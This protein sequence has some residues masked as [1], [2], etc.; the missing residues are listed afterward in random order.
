[1]MLYIVWATT[2]ISDIRDQQRIREN[3]QQ[4]IATC[5][6]NLAGFVDRWNDATPYMKV[7]EFVRQKIMWDSGTFEANSSAAIPLE[8]AELHL[9]QLRKSYLHRAV[10]GMIEDMIYGRSIHQDILEEDD[11][12]MS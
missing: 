2:P 5:A 10:L 9:E 3:N 8:V 6:A 11:R 4:A 12:E 1:M 7:L